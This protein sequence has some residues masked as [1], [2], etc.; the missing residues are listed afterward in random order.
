MWRSLKVSPATSCARRSATVVAADDVRSWA[1]RSTIFPLPSSPLGADDHGRRRPGMPGG[2]LTWATA[3]PRGYRAATAAAVV[4]ARQSVAAGAGGKPTSAAAAS[5]RPSPR[6]RRRSG[7]LRG[8]AR[9]A[10][11]TWSP[12]RRARRSDGRRYCSWGQCR[13]GELREA[14]QEREL[15]HVRGAVAVLRQVDFGETLLVGLLAVVVLVAVDEGDQIGVLLDRPGLAQV[16]ED[17]PLVVALLDRAGEL[18]TMIRTSRSRASTFSER[19]DLQTS[20]TGSRQ[21]RPGQL[22]VVD[23]Q[24]EFARASSAA[25]TERI[26]ISVIDRCRRRR[27]GHGELVAAAVSRGQSSCAFAGAEALRRPW[28]QAHQALGDLELHLEREH[29]DRHLCRT[30]RFAATQSPK[31]D[32]PIDG[33]AA[34][35]IRCR[36]EP[37][38]GVELRADAIR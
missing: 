23:D 3:R 19:R 27:S 16:G 9:T 30:A 8:S 34:M 24:A 31:A 28:P 18:R 6:S 5:P 26:S 14:A 7:A 36:A 22:E 32:F 17:R 1:S 2:Q 37:G 33:R 15:H 13:V 25:A 38:G 10:R 12:R 20:C 29:R 35:T 4:A 11:R 21:R